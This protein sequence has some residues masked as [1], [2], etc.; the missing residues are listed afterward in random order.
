MRWLLMSLAVCSA[1]WSA[2]EARA[3]TVKFCFLFCAVERDASTVDSFC[4]S[5]ERV[6]RE[7]GDGASLQLSR[8]T[9]QRRTARNEALY[10]CKCQGWK[11]RICEGL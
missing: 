8:L 9:I 7:P 10:R 4:Q 3:D 5:Y 6:L 11:N 2:T 1:I